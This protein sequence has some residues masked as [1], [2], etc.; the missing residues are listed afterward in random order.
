[1]KLRFKL[2]KSLWERFSDILGNFTLI[3]AVSFVLPGLFDRPNIEGVIL[4]GITTAAFF[5]FSLGAARKY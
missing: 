5:I 4:G 3:P 2:T 1:M